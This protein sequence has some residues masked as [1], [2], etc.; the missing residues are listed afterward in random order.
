MSWKIISQL[1]RTVSEETGV[2]IKD[3]GGKIPVALAFPNTYFTGMSNLGFQAVY[4]L[5]NQERDVVCERF[6][7]PDGPMAVEH[8]RTG[9][10][11]AVPG[12]PEA[13]DRFRTGGV[14]IIP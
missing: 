8:Y 3:W 5:F 9:T 6:F 2:R 1:R 4:G 12:I 11:L 13:F 7:L 10:P 14:F